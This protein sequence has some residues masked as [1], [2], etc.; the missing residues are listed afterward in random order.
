M[1]STL[2]KSRA[3]FELLGETTH[4]KER[5]PHTRDSDERKRGERSGEKVGENFG[6]GKIAGLCGVALCEKR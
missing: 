4:V 3:T 1:E 2:Q 6:I 5:K